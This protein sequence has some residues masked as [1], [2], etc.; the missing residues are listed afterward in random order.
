MNYK[1]NSLSKKPELNQ[2]NKQLFSFDIGYKGAKQFVF[3]TY[4]NIYKHIIESKESNFYEDNTFAN[5]IKLFVDID[6]KIIF[7]TTLARD[8]Y[9]NNLLSIIITDINIQ[10][11]RLFQINDPKI[12]I[13]VSDTLLKLSLHL[14]YP[15]IIFNTIYEMKY[16]MTDIQ[17]IDHSV[18]KI[19]CFRMLFC[20]KQGKNNK[21][22][23]FRG[24][25][26]SCPSNDFDLFLDC[27][28]CHINNI[29]SVK[30][31]IS[32]I[33]K[34]EYNKKV[35]TA[36]KF[37][38][39]DY[40]YKNIDLDKLKISLNKLF[41]FSNDYSQWLIIAFCLKDLYLSSTKEY[42][43]KIYNLFDEFSK[44]S[45]SYNKTENKNIFM[46]LE[47]KIDIN[48]LFKLSN[49]N[50]YFAP[51]YDYQNIIFNPKNH[52]NIIIKNE[53]YIDIDV[54][55]LLKNKYI[56]LKSATGSGKTTI[57]KKII[58]KMNIK[59]I[60]SITSRVNLA[61]EH[62]KHLN[63]NFYSNLRYDEFN[64]CHNLVI[65]LE[66]LIKCNYSL[67]KDGIVVLYEVNS[68]LSHL[69]SP[70][71]DKRRRDVYMYLIELVQNAKY[72][73]CLDAD[74]SDWNIKFLQE[75]Q[76]NEYIIYYNTIKNK[77]NIDST[78]YICPQIM[79][80][81]M[82]LHI[83]D[84]KYFIACFD[85]LRQMNK[86]IE[87]LSQFGNKDEWLIYS[88]EVDYGLIDTSTWNDKYV[89]YTPTIIYGIDYNFKFI[90]VFCFVYKNHLNP[91]Q[92]Y[93][94]ISRARKQ[95][96]VHVYCKEKE[97]F[98]KYKSV[99]D[100]VNEV[101]LYEKNF[102]C[103]LPEYNN[104]IDIDDKPYRIM[105]YNYKFMDSIL[106]TNIRGYLIDI[107]ENR[108]YKI[109]YN[110]C[111]KGD[112]M[113]KKEIT[114]TKIKERIIE[115]LSLDK[116]NLSEFEQTLVSNDKNIE[117]HFNLRIFLYSDI[118]KKLT[119]SIEEN[120]F[121]E[122]LK[123]KYSTIKICKELLSVLGMNSLDDLNKEVSKKFNSVIE[124]DWLNENF[125][126]IKK[127][128]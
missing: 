22:V 64:N 102:G 71:L 7:T 34:K 103:L 80:D 21:L 119:I 62:V 44:I 89:F 5:K 82:E 117:K 113:D 107:M 63:L 27:S 1:I 33:I 127:N 96:I 83:K 101:Q 66:S 128:V 49:D 99:E 36:L 104:Y 87:Y 10:L 68:L 118:N 19:G 120:L 23:F 46:N 100:V 56:F 112:L 28:I 38:N 18:Y 65:Q 126:I 58:D 9:A 105:Y 29:E 31:N 30:I 78:F 6:E 72:V 59:N 73:I 8:K 75:I 116:K 111:I 70:T 52:T 74:L 79:I 69:R 55:L 25:N 42:Q 43:T 109:T 84:N 16:F 12:I 88:S 20:S 50:F 37:N 15:E 115:L 53:I 106:K 54:D 3:D 61:S 39:R 121:V 24:S 97:Y 11:Y 67:Y 26:Y 123:N 60:I 35:N 13:L 76:Q 81:K 4:E 108:G 124:N 92:I 57:L 45:K 86:I 94:M 48:Y 125:N 47:P 85:S 114:K 90:D 51:F 122:T 95:N 41:N 40:I 93:Q 17:L 14:I 110:N 91:L 77:N 32:Q 2:E 98:I